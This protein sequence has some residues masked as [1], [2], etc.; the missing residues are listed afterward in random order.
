MGNA[1]AY[2]KHGIIYFPARKIPKKNIVLKRMGVRKNTFAGD[3]MS[4]LYD[5]YFKDA[6]NLQDEYKQYYI[7]EFATVIIFMEEHLNMEHDL[8]VRLAKGNYSMKHCTSESIERNIETL[9]YD[10]E[11]KQMFSNAIG[12]IEDEDSDWIYYE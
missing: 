10:A 4:R 3:A 6:V 8:A 11:L 12:G 7:K 2:K 1:I 9:N 5:Y